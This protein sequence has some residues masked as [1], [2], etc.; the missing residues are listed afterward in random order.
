M[1]LRNLKNEIINENGLYTIKT[2]TTFSDCVEGDGIILAMSKERKQLI[3]YTTDLDIISVEPIEYTSMQEYRFKELVFLVFKKNSVYK[4]ISECTKEIMMM[5]KGNAEWIKLYTSRQMISSNDMIDEIKIYQL[6]TKK[7][8]IVTTERDREELG[9][10]SDKKVVAEIDVDTKQTKK[11]FILENLK[12][13][14]YEYNRNSSPR[15][16]FLRR[17]QWNNNVWDKY[18]DK[19]YDLYTGNCYKMPDFF[20]KSKKDIIQCYSSKEILVLEINQEFYLYI[21]GYL[22]YQ[23]TSEEYESV[24]YNLRKK[25][26]KHSR[27]LKN[28]EKE[29]FFTVIIGKNLC[30]W[31]KKEKPE[32]ITL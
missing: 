20:V 10:I 11:M 3:K 2:E 32:M 14:W 18:V 7:Y 6:H 16:I 30:I 5:S 31:K 23:Y 8:I 28:F 17:S 13:G 26:T 27:E 21:N 12:N 29:Y 9:Y 15:F 4:G 19:V 1:G 22:V 24:L 25:I